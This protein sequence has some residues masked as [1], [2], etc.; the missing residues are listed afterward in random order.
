[1]S[2][3]IRIPTMLLKVGDV[4]NGSLTDY[5][6]Q[7]VTVAPVALDD[8]T[9]T[10]VTDAYQDG[11]RW[12]GWT[13]MLGGTVEVSFS[14]AEGAAAGIIIA[15]TAYPAEVVLAA[16]RRFCCTCGLHDDVCPGHAASPP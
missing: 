11:L 7:R 12:T 16:L 3:L 1:M 15:L 6:P 5:K 8:M 9:C 13:G 10:W 4:M 14:T 2:F